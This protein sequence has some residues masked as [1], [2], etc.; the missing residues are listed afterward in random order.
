[1]FFVWM[2]S[3]HCTAIDFHR[4]IL[5]RLAIRSIP[6][7]DNGNLIFGS[8]GN[9]QESLSKNLE[10]FLSPK[11]FNWIS[12]LISASFRPGKKI[13]RK[14]AALILL[15]SSPNFQGCQKGNGIWNLA[16]RN[17]FESCGN[18]FDSLSG[19]AAENHYIQSLDDN[20]GIRGEEGSLSSL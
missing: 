17:T 19:C 6:S 3:V 9:M 14:W 5:L 4:C 8:I 1:M 20:R 16:S 12:N 11:I 15:S 10:K 2:H 18:L 13:E 7:L